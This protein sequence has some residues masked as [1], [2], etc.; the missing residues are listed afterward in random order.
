MTELPDDNPKTAI[1]VK[2]PSFWEIPGSA[3]LHLGRAF[4]YGA[5]KYGL[6]N[7]REKAITSSTYINAAMRHIEAWKDGEECAEDSSVHHLAHA[8]ACLGIILDAREIGNLND[9]RGPQGTFPQMLK[10]FTSSAT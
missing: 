3:L 10:R 2:K 8:M 4:A 1:G 5:R 7:W 9:D 6:F